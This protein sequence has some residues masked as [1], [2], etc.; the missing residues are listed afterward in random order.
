[1][2]FLFAQDIHGGCHG[3]HGLSAETT[4]W[5]SL[6]RTGRGPRGLRVPRTAPPVNSLG[7]S[8]ADMGKYPGKQVCIQ[9]AGC[10]IFLSLL[11]KMA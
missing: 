10:K 5:D 1:M 6:M 11:P 4:L 2:Q 9:H 7:V 3:N 8:Q